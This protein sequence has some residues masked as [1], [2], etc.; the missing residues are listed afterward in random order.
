VWRY[1]LIDT[2]NVKFLKANVPYLTVYDDGGGGGGGG[3]Y[4]DDDDD[5]DDDD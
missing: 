3:D 5:D 4:D 1:W 2:R